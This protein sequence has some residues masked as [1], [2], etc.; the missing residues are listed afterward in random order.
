VGKL[1]LKPRNRLVE[2]L[3]FTEKSTPVVLFRRTNTF[4][5]VSFSWLFFRANSIS[6]AGL[7]I[8]KLFTDWSTS[9]SDVLANMG[10]D[11]EMILITALSLVLLFLLDRM[12]TYGGE[13]DDSPILVKDGS[14]V[15]IVWA[16][17]LCWALLL[18]RD[19]I[20]RFIY[21]QF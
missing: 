20:S 6:D 17:L 9:S 2:K 21:F 3:G 11:L 1:T 19:M 4:L 15:Y 14:F 7:L 16:V 8:K 5:L 12:I 18:S 10:L 13:E